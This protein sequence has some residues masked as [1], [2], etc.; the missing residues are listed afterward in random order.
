MPKIPEEYYKTKK[1]QPKILAKDV[2]IAC[3]GK[4]KNSRGGQ[5]IACAGTGRKNVGSK[6][7]PD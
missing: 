1:K 7:R 3:G 6:Y 5:C 4:G 2:C